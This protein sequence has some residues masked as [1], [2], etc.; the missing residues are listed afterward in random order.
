[1]GHLFR[2]LRIAEHQNAYSIGCKASLL[3]GRPVS[4]II[5]AEQT[6]GIAGFVIV[7]W[8]EVSGECPVVSFLIPA[9]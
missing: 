5:F 7:R 3:P 9:W 8:E 1:M 2:D 4:I 6:C